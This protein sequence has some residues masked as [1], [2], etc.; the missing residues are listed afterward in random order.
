M[1]SQ[2]KAGDWEGDS[3]GTSGPDLSP[4]YLHPCL[5]T[6]LQS[7]QTGRRRGPTSHGTRKSRA[8]AAPHRAHCE[9]CRELWLSANLPLGTEDFREAGLEM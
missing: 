1:G 7:E 4:V 5:G 6:E 3:S 9:L 2:R 8:S